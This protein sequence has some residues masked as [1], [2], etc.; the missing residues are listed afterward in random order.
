MAYLEQPAPISSRLPFN[1]RIVP[2]G[3]RIRLL[4]LLS[5]LD[6]GPA[7]FPAY[8]IERSI[9][10]DVDPPRYSGRPA[11]LLL[12]HDVDSG[13]ELSMIDS[14]R[15]MERERS[16]VSS[17][18]FVPLLS[19]PEETTARALV[20]EGCEVYWHGI[21][22][23]GRLPYLAPTEIRSAFDAV[24]RSSPWA[25][26]LMRAF[27]AGQAL[28]STPLID[29]VAERFEI[30]L[31][32]PDTE[33][34]G[35]Y[36]KTAGCGTVYPFELRGVLEIPFTLAQDV[37]LRQ[38]QRL[39]PDGVLDAWRS[40]LRYIKSIGGVAALNVHPIWVSDRD[41]GM[42]ETYSKFL[43]GVADDEQLLITTPSALRRILLE[44]PRSTAP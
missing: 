19:W 10:I 7:T 28:A 18:G 26:E 1:Y 2:I 23:D 5:R 13:A 37:Y 35:P 27:R 33:L 29:A 11:A 42:R 30:D 36:G 41:P 39:T 38:V 4:R 43:D 34:G 8:P 24:A 3:A 20:G 14:I 44:P 16:L 25:V 31:S 40:K 6:R 21:G 15:A 17:W 9:D 32:I 22:H 12:T